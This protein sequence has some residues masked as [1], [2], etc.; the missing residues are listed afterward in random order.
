MKISTSL[1]AISFLGLLLAPS[2]SKDKLLENSPA[3]ITADNLFVNKE[4]FDNGL[5]GLY[6]EA[7]RLYSGHDYGESNNLMMEESVIGV[8][9]AY[10]N[11]RSPNE[12][13]FNLWG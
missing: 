7:R 10:G 3:I 1:I 12:D 13:I 6:N 11:Y 5:S 4:G 9:N 2:C 8:D